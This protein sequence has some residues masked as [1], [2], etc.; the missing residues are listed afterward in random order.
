MS[1]TPAVSFVRIG[2]GP[3]ALQVIPNGATSF[4]AIRVKV[5]SAL[6]EAA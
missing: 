2:Q 3:T 5:S 4:A 1:G 6:F